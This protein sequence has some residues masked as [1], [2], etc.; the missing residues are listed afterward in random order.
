MPYST[1]P[2]EIAI[3]KY[4]PETRNFGLFAQQA[5]IENLQSDPNRDRF[6]QPAPLLTPIPSEPQTPATPAPLPAP[7]LTNAPAITV[8][9]IEVTGNTLISDE[10]I[11]KITAPFTGKTLSLEQLRGVA[12][13][14]TQLYLNRNYLPS[15]TILVNQ[16]IEAGIIQIRIIEGSLTAIEIDGTRRLNPNY[17]RSRIKLGETNP[18]NNAGIEEQLKLLRLDPLIQN[19]EA[20]LRAGSELGESV[21]TVKVAE[22]NPFYGTIGIDNY[23]PSSIGSKRIGLNLG[24]RNLTGIGDEIRA[25]YYFTQQNGSDIFDFAYRL[26]VNAMNGTI[27]LRA[28]PNRTQII[29]APFKQFGFQGEQEYYEISFRQPLIRSLREEFVLSVGFTLE[30][31]KTFVSEDTLS[32]FNIDNRT[33]IIKFG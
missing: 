14:I 13:S 8:Q 32:F 1:P 29:E 15:R 2:P 19:I 18:L 17:I 10:E 31:G 24:Y 28:A 4:S 7:I 9:K 21:L 5:P 25:S 27:Q 20:S 30:D 12:D 26:P 22:A 33:S 16:T 11:N 3:F 23:S 6:L